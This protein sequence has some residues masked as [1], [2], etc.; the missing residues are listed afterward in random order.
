MSSLQLGNL[1][2]LAR[3]DQW[4][5]WLEDL[6]DVIF[7]NGLQDYLNSIVQEPANNAL[8]R[9]KSEWIT[10]YET[11]GAMIHMAL[12][13]E[14]RER[15]R[16]H[17][18]DRA[19]HRGR[20]ILIYVQKAVKLVSGNMDKLYN[21]MW[22]DLCRTDFKTWADF[23]VEFRRLHSKLKETDQEVSRKAT[24][25]HMFDRVRTYLPV[26]CE[27]NEARFLADPDV[28]KLLLELE[29]RGRQLEYKG[30]TLA[31]LKA[32]GDRSPGDH[33]SGSGSKGTES[34]R[35][36]KSEK[37]YQNNGQPQ[38]QPH[39]KNRDGNEKESTSQRER[40]YCDRCD[41]THPGDCWPICDDCGVR[42]NTKSRCRKPR[43]RRERHGDY[44]RRDYSPDPRGRR[45]RQ[46]DYSRRG[47]SSGPNR[48]REQRDDYSRREY[49]PDSE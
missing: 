25:I 16:Y 15:M 47:Y 43:G 34:E 4:L 21:S 8:D 14:I 26:W 31:S 13:P 7:L 28:E 23:I 39:H 3:E 9:Q 5:L 1:T 30:V 20:D 46:D 6:T 27:I 11:V 2:K 41:K 36:Q 40:R 44:S 37:N 38:G 22:R 17:G 19:Q 48:R 45:N 42:H 49:S 33:V 18:Y 35:K 12:S 29:S 10:K 24:C 32:K